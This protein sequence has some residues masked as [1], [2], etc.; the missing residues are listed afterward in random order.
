MIKSE[1]ARAASRREGLKDVF[2][3]GF[4]KGGAGR[5]LLV[6]HE[7][8]HAR[9]ENACAFSA[10]ALVERGGVCAADASRYDQLGSMCANSILLPGSAFAHRY[11]SCGSPH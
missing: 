1:A 4:L 8:K 10:Q 9:A 7:K 3:G 6:T 5:C 2:K 11:G